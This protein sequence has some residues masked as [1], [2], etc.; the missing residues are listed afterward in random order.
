[1]YLYSSLAIINLAIKHKS[2]FAKLPYC[3]KGH[4]LVKLLNSS[5]YLYTYTLDLNAIIVYFK[6]HDNI[7]VL[8]GFFFYSKPGHIRSITIDQLRRDYYKKNKLLIL[9][10]IDG[11]CTSREALQKNQGGII[12]AE[13]GK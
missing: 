1:M 8:N 12:L 6:K 4:E 3:K 5:G 2:N 11:I 9:S 13:I 7:F 10:T